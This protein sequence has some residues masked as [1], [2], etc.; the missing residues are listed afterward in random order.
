MPIINENDK[1]MLNKDRS[2]RST[3][4][5]IDRRYRTLDRR[6]PNKAEKNAG[7]YVM[8]PKVID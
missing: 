6:S 5:H 8:W 4:H 1:E 3:T 2:I 7:K